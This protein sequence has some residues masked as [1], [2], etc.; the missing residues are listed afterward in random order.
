MGPQGKEM[1]W[2]F[3]TGQ[4]PLVLRLPVPK[5]LLS[6][7]GG[8][9]PEELQGPSLLCPCRGHLGG[10]WS[11]RLVLVSGVGWGAGM[12]GAAVPEGSNRAVGTVDGRGAGKSKH[13]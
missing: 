3:A 1:Q 6:G 7:V 4:R 11:L 10:P 12:G 8:Q 13:I 2:D 5:T 9:W